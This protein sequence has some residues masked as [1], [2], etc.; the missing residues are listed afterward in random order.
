M[1]IVTQ[2]PLEIDRKAAQDRFRRGD[3]VAQR[4]LDGVRCLVEICGGTVTAQNRVGRGLEIQGLDATRDCIL[5]GELVAGLFTAFDLLA[6]DGR[7][8][9][10]NPL[11]IRL[12]NLRDL[13]ISPIVESGVGWGFVERAEREGWEG[14]V[15]KD[16]A[17]NYRIDGREYAPRSWKLKFK[18]TAS[19]IV[20]GYNGY[21]A[22][23]SVQIATVDGVERGSVAV[24]GAAAL[25][26]GSI[27]EVQFL[28]V[29][30]S[31]KL[32]E[33]VFKQVRSDCLKSACVIPAALLMQG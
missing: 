30:K 14:V 28:A 25:P 21:N 24:R 16:P 13:A 6:L 23:E 27:I 4:K 19:F 1:N 3:V 32:R 31:G 20:T 7:P 22:N 10:G 15:L 33:P 18:K 12:Q 8:I 9:H 26:T 17:A 5:D 11:S 29:H 2:Q